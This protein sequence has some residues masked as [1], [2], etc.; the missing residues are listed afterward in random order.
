MEAELKRFQDTIE[1]AVR[2]LK[3]DPQAFEQEILDDLD[4]ATGCFTACIESIK[5]RL[6]AQD[7]RGALADLQRIRPRGV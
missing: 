6:Q 5:G 1:H 4:V 3:L 2:N 7:Y